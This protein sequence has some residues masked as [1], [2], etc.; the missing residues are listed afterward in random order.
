MTDLG[1]PAWYAGAPKPRL[2]LNV[3]DGDRAGAPPCGEP[4]TGRLAPAVV[5]GRGT[6]GA[7]ATTTL[8]IASVLCGPAGSRNAKARG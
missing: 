4:T 8:K 1:Y 7:P 2:T 6:T 3:I 5:E